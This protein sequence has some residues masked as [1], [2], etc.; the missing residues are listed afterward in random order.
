MK[1]KLEE[2]AIEAGLA[3][4]GTLFEDE[5]ITKFAQL[6]THELL[7]DLGTL[8]D[9]RVPASEYVG[10]LLEKVTKEWW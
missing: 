7:F 9:H 6:V 1:P 8:V 3:C 4:D 10:R 5:A 2:L